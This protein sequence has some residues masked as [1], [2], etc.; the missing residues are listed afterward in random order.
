VSKLYFYGG[1]GKEK[2]KD[3]KESAALEATLATA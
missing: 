2:K 3:K 1:R